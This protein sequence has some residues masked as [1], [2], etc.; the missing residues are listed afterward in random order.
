MKNDPLNE[1]GKRMYK[2]MCDKFWEDAAKPSVYELIRSGKIKRII[3]KNND[4]VKQ[5]NHS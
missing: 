1:L 3:N 5:A 4:C 2:E